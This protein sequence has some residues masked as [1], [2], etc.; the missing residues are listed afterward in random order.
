MIGPAVTIGGIALLTAALHLRDP[1]DSGSWGYCPSAA[2]GFWCPL[3]HE[4]AGPPG[5]PLSRVRRTTQLP[6]VQLTLP[7]TITTIQ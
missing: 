3:T 4:G 7:L 1:H 5:R 2:L 6:V